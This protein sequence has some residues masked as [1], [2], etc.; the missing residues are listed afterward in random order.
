MAHERSL[1]DDLEIRNLLNRVSN[2]NDGGTLEAYTDCWTED[3]LWEMPGV[4]WRGRDQIAAGFVRRRESR[5][6][7]PGTGVR[8]LVTNQVIHVDGTDTATSESYLILVRETFTAPRI[9]GI[10]LNQDTFHRTA[11]GWRI[12]RR[13]ITPAEPD[14]SSR[15]PA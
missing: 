1:A 5:H 11:A 2:L 14:A 13:V 8:H 3:A 4:T 15:L 9:A 10:W 6:A 12:A 7:G